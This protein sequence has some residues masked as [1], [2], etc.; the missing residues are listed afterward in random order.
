MM[1]RRA[2]MVGGVAVLAAPLAAGAQ[3]TQTMPRIG[4]L[5]DGSPSSNAVSVAAF[6]QGLRDLGYVEGRTIGVE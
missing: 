5:T 1:D 6:Q 3:Q 2:F 4:F